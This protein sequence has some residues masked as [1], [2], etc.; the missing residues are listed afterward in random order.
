MTGEASP[1]RL[2][3]APTCD[4]IPGVGPGKGDWPVE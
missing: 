1:E 4:S 2:Q 3:T